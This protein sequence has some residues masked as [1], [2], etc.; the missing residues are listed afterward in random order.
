MTCIVFCNP[1]DK[2]CIFCN[3][4]TNL[5]HKHS[6][7]NRNR[8]YLRIFSGYYITRYTVKEHFRLFIKFLY[9]NNQPVACSVHTSPQNT[10][11][12]KPKFIFTVTQVKI[13]DNSTTLYIKFSKSRK[14]RII[15]NRC[16]PLYFNTYDN[17]RKIQCTCKYYRRTYN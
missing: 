8:R 3:I 13:A 9:L 7:I 4:V 12:H 15:W 5:M 16:I 10:V 2:K 14:Y 17:L 6:V 1:T 11:N